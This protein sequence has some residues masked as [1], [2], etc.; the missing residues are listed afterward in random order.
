MQPQ[1]AHRKH[2]VV[3]VVEQSQALTKIRTASNNEFWIKHHELDI[4]TPKETREE[5]ARR[6]LLSRMTR[7]LANQTCS[8]DFLQY[9]VANYDHIFVTVKAGN[10]DNFE[11]EWA[12]V[13]GECFTGKYSAGLNRWGLGT[14]ITFPTPPANVVVGDLNVQPHPVVEGHSMVHNNDFFW[15]VVAVVKAVGSRSAVVQ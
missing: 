10:E 7:I 8:S 3:T 13:T 2:G 9:V 4:Y 5:R 14:Q 15:Q 12:A 1:Y 6:L 11:N